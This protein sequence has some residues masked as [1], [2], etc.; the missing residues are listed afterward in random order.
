[1]SGKSGISAQVIT[2]NEEK[3]IERALTSLNFVDEIILVD[4]GSRDATVEIAK[5]FTDRVYFNE[6]KGFS[7]QRNFA[8]DKCS[9]DWVL[10]LD[11][12]EE[13]TPECADRIKKIMKERTNCTWF[14]IR[15]KEHF[16]GTYM[17]W[18]IDNP[19]Y[20]IRLF[21][22]SNGRYKGEV[23]EYPRMEGEM[24]LI[25][26]PI[27][28]YSF[29]SF[30]EIRQKAY[31]YAKFSAN[32]KFEKSERQGYVYR[33]FSGLAQFLKSYISHLGILDGLYGFYRSAGDGLEFY[34]RQ[35]FLWELWRKKED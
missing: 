21:R 34:Y 32:E 11:A 9:H 10:H 23:H 29:D 24:G 3:N 17:K 7:P 26:E 27:N 13:V 4:S 25:H 35:R 22:K 2:L 16:N 8:L 1:M 19:S 18:G 12:D 5:R 30:E 20:Q 6:W 33:Y 31:K 14:K 15:R 28:H